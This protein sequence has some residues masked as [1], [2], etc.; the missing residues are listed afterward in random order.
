[1]QSNNDYQENDIKFLYQVPCKKGRNIALV[2]QTTS[3]SQKSK[4]I[5][6]GSYEII[7]GEVSNTS[8]QI[9]IKPRYVMES[10]AINKNKKDN[11]FFEYYEDISFSETNNLK[12]FIEWVNGSKIFC[13]NAT[14]VMK[15]LEKEF[16][17]WD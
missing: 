5:E 1:M 2:I 6:L 8:F 12:N 13:H 15:E 14:F 16:S 7:N 9:K 4:V 3:L 10:D 11:D 17:F